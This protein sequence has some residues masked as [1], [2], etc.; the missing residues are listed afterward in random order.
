[1]AFLP[2]PAPGFEKQRFLGTWHIIASNYGFWKN[3]IHPTVTYGEVAG[4]TLA[5][6]D[7]LSFEKRSLLGG[8]FRP[9]VLEGI[10]RQHGEPGRFM[11]RGTGLLSLI[12][13][14]WCVVAVGPAYDW[15]VTYFAR[16]NVGTAPGVDLYARTASLRAEQVS[17]ILAQVRQ[18]AFM[19]QACEGMFETVQYGVPP[20]LYRFEASGAPGRE[21]APAHDLSI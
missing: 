11:W 16:S 3:R 9:G 8:A 13:S 14:P 21:R 17:Q 1:M 15:A 12:R 19:A 5:M 10:D 4:D 2:P 7:R 18:D 20:G 6:S